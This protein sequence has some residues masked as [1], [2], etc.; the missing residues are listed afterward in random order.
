MRDGSEH[1]NRYVWVIE[2]EGS[3]VRSVHEYMDT[4]YAVLVLSSLISAGAEGDRRS[5]L[6]REDG[7]AARLQAAHRSI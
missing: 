7:L 6:A 1:H 4:A 2:F 3:L 5:I